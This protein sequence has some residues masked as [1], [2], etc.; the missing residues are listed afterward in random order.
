MIPVE[1]PLFLGVFQAEA[2]KATK[3]LELPSA[4]AFSTVTRS[5]LLAA[6]AVAR[7][8]DDPDPTSGPP[9]MGQLAA[10]IVGNTLAAAEAER[11]GN[12][13]VAD[14]LLAQ[15]KVELDRMRAALTGSHSVEP[16]GE[17]AP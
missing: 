9:T 4:S 17:V 2:M 6:E 5:Y 15:A 11:K 3:T 8:E 12:P 13:A 16:L 1:L 14:R 7:P 10:A